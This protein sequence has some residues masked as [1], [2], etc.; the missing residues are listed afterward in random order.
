MAHRTPTDVLVL[1]A[2]RILGYADTARIAARFGLPTGEADEHLLDAQAC[3]WVTHT[4]YAGDSGWSLTE[5]GKAHGEHLLSDELDATRARP[6]VRQ[7]HQD[8][9]PHNETVGKACTAWQ[10][11]EM[12][13][14]EQAV[15]LGTTITRLEEPS[16]ALA[17]L[18]ARL[19]ARLDRFA[20]YHQRFAG[21]LDRA[22]SD[23]GWITATDRDSCHRVWFE[24]HEDLIAT[25]GLTR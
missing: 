8:F 11:A 22:G 1:H 3:G 4:S 23:P 6:V 17:D 21:A 19:T 2:V 24:L 13:I 12:D 20:D 25:L 14:G 9:L 7:V 18:E 15:T 10:L 5:T 16:R